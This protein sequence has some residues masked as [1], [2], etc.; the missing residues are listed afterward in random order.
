[1]RDGPRKPTCAECPHNLYYSDSIPKRAMG[2][3]MH[4]GERFCTGGKKARRFKRGDPKI[5]VPSWCPKRK[6]PCEL[7]IYV[8]KSAGSWYLHRLLEQDLGRN[9]S[10]DGSHYA[11]EQSLT[12]ELAPWEFWKRL[13]QSSYRELLDVSLEPHSV[14]EI[15]DGLKPVS[16]CY[17]DGTFVMVPFFDAD[18]ARKN[19]KEE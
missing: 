7:R 2:V 9:L 16:F 17:R 5:Y 19:K 11:L 14:V 18:V 12:T 10:P 15:D 1:M 6:S 4:L 8:F 13:E 3:M